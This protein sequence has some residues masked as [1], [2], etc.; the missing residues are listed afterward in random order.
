[1]LAETG[2]TVTNMKSIKNYALFVCVCFNF[3]KKY[4][5]KPNQQFCVRQLHI[6][7]QNNLSSDFQ[8]LLWVPILFYTLLGSHLWHNILWKQAD[9]KQNL[10]FWCVCVLKLTLNTIIWHCMVEFL[11]KSTMLWFL[12]KHWS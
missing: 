7:N 1:M 9:S 4:I 3:I 2:D 6:N 12:Y 10:Q 11:M 8:T 5:D